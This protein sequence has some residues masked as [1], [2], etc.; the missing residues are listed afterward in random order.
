M[1]APP[2]TSTCI[3]SGYV[4][5]ERPP[6]AALN[7]RSGA[8]NFHKLTTTKSGPEHHHFTFL[9]DFDVPETSIFKM[10]LNSTRSGAPRVSASQT[11][12]SQSAS[13]TRP[14]SSGD[15]HFHAQ[16]RIKLGPETRIFTL[17][18]AQAR[19]GARI[20][21]LDRE[22]VPKPEPIFTVPR[23]MTYQTLGGEYPQGGGG[24]LAGMFC[25]CSNFLGAFE[26][27][28]CRTAFEV[29]SNCI[30]TAF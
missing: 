23:H 30:M 27:E 22:L 13:Q 26:V 4:P 6:F 24:G 28:K 17:K 19:S 2:P 25:S 1:A 21:T 11:P 10:S 18:T 7:V 15:S 16:N 8:Y 9:R 29:Y 5:R 3:F 14:G 12:A 20:F